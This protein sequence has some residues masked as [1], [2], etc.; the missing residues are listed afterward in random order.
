[1]FKN[2]LYSGYYIGDQG[3]YPITT[4][5][6]M[7]KG[8]KKMRNEVTFEG[9]VNKIWGNEKFVNASVFNETDGYK[10]YINAK[11]FAKG[12]ERRFDVIKDTI[13][14][15]Y[16]NDKELKLDG[17]ISWSKEGG[18]YILIDKVYSR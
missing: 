15:C 17:K 12:N 4:P 9:K 1:M 3:G 13:E 11:I 5:N 14:E 7:I 6:N 18:Y 10:L 8:E 2:V 16:K